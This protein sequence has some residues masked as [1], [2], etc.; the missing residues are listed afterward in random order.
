MLDIAGNRAS[1]LGRVS[2]GG[3]FTRG[4]S[5]VQIAWSKKAP[6]WWF[7]SWARRV[8]WLG[9]TEEYVQRSLETSALGRVKLTSLRDGTALK[10]DQL[11]EYQSVP[12]SELVGSSTGLLRMVD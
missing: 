10:L 5:I 4:D 3:E 12:K 2:T 11:G 6:N 8:S 1:S 7:T 9:R